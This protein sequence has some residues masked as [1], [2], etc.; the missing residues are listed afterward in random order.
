MAIFSIRLAMAIRRS[1]VISRYHYSTF[2]P[3]R[4]G[5]IGSDKWPFFRSDWPIRPYSWSGPLQMAKT[6]NPGGPPLS[7]LHSSHDRPNLPPPDPPDLA[8]PSRI[9]SV[10]AIRGGPDPLEPLGPLPDPI[11]TPSGPPS[12]PSQIGH[13]WSPSGPLQIGHYRS[14]S[15]WTPSDPLRLAKVGAPRSAHSVH[16]SHPPTMVGGKL[17]IASVCVRAFERG[18]RVHDVGTSIHTQIA[19]PVGFRCITFVS[20]F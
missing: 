14:P 3:P 16:P 13:Y 4:I 7:A 8:N 19:Q 12:G 2:R 18:V 9:S 20:V 6:A 17:A 1:H 10:L 11:R 5:Q 15:R